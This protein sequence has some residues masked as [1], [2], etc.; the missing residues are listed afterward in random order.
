[1][2]CTSSARLYGQKIGAPALAYARPASANPPG[3]GCLRQ[4]QLHPQGDVSI[5]AVTP[6]AAG[7]RQYEIAIVYQRVDLAPAIP[8]QAPGLL[9]RAEEG[10]LDLRPT[11]IGHAASLF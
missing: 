10:A 9:D 8:E 11:T 4:L 5:D 2:A 3:L 6:D 7:C 1:M